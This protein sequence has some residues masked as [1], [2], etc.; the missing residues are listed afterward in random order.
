MQHFI[1]STAS[2]LGL[3]II[4]PLIGTGLYLTIRLKL[5]QM[6]QFGHSWKVISGIYDDPEEIGDINHIQALSAALSA[7]IGIGN[8]AGVATAI[9]FGGPGAL[10]WM[11]VTAFVGMATKFSEATLALKFR[12]IHKDGS[13]S[14]GPMYYIELGLGKSWKPLAVIFA[15]CTIISSFGSGNT[16]QAFTVADS[17][18]ADF[19]IPNWVTGLVLA[20]LVGMVIIGG[21]KRIG[22]VASRLVPFMALVYIISALWVIGSNADKLPDAIKLIF[23]S[24]FSARAGIGG[25]AGSTFMMALLWGVKRGLFSNESGQGSAP[26]AHAAAK[27]EEPVREGTV[28]MVGPFIDTLVICTLTGL[29]IITSGAWNTPFFTTIDLDQPTVVTGM[30]K[31]LPGGKVDEEDLFVGRRPILGGNVLG[32]K[33]IHNNSFFIDPEIVQTYED[34][35]PVPLNQ[36]TFE[37]NKDGII[38]IYRVELDSIG[39]K[40]DKP[41]NEIPLENIRIEGKGLRNGSLLTA[42][43]FESGLGGKWGNWMVTIAVF[44]FAISTAISWSYYGDRATVY[45]FGIKGVKIYRM[46]YVVV[47]F[48]GANLALEAAWG[49]GDIALACM[50]IP[51][52]F[53]LVLLAKKVQEWKEE[54]FSREHVPVSKMHF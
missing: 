45:L 34:G 5:V 11:W 52:L 13:A 4:I 21:I 47:V 18:G 54:Y 3:I 9:H 48:I 37:V 29:T 20:T 50:A 2:L 41:E 16:V 14:G 17:F 7:T 12:Q 8:I 1:D 46:V 42:Q 24:A 38:E 44:L 31:L 51:N 19:G 15:F 10:F 43:A 39:R 36:G 27:T 30:A 33:F 53:A 6:M 25:F 26:I 49:F 23:N 40:I 35:E 22:I 28:A 32:V